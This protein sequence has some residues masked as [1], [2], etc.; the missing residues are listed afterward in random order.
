MLIWLVKIL[1]LV[2]SSTLVLAACSQPKPPPNA[3]KP[4]VGTERK[5]LVLDVRTP[6]EFQAGHIAGAVNVPIDE[7][8]VRIRQ[9][10]PERDT[11]IAVHCQSG[12][13]SARAKKMMNDE[14]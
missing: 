14:G 6:E 2:I 13:R 10:A 3:A 1:L 11:S 5:R 7:L 9:V 8:L 4:S 12:G